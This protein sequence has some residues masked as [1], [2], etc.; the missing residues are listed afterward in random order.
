MRLHVT[1][2]LCGHPLEQPNHPCLGLN[3]SGLPKALGPLQSLVKGDP[4]DRRFLL[5][6]LSVSRAISVEGKVDLSSITSRGIEIS[7]SVVS[8]FV[9]VLKDVGWTIDRE[10]LE[11]R[12]SHLS[13]KAGPNGQAM[14]GS[15][16]DAHNLTPEMLEHIGVLGGANL[17]QRIKS[18]ITYFPSDR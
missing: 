12:T 14:M 4:W 9:N 3:R 8:E 11:W 2:Y 17:V 6:L 18:I 7:D 13:T 15:V 1:R 16:H 5:T 10:E